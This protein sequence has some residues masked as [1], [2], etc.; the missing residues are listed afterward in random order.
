MSQTTAQLVSEINGGAIAGMRN[1]IINGDMRFVQRGASFPAATPGAYTIDRWIWGQLG[2]MVCTVTQAIDSPNDTFL[3]SFKADVT[4]S[5]GS[6][7]T[8]DYSVVW[9]RIEGT[10]VRDLIGTTFT[11]SF[12]VKSPKTGTHCVAFRNG[13]TF[14]V[15]RSYV[16]EYTV[17]TANTWEYKTVTVANGLIT[18]GTWDWATGVGLDVLFTLASG[19]T[20]QTTA[21]AWQTG[22][23]LAT[24]NQVNV[25][26]NTANDFFITGVQLE[27]GSVATPFERRLS[28]VEFG[29]CQRYYQSFGA[30]YLTYT[31]GVGTGFSQTITFPTM[32]TSPVVTSSGTTFLNA[33]G[34]NIVNITREKLI[35]GAA[36][37]NAGGVPVSVSS[38]L[39]LSAEL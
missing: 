35:F 4:T 19:T 1:R 22:N 32:R 33:S 16:T 18:A 14:P 24:T 34:V 28:G 10:K 21:N 2:T 30:G 3:S 20:F 6:L 37:N 26:D 38:T 39:T 7:G 31:A 15:D 27:P 11:V 13:G 23:F 5:S 25:M 12:W 17:L 29:L 9:Q 8:T 36:C